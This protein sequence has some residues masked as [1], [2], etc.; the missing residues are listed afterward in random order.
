MQLP[1]KRPSSLG[2]FHEQVHVLPAIGWQLVDT[3]QEDPFQVEPI[4]QWL[5]IWRG[6]VLLDVQ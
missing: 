1:S 5:G 2:S 3:V 6:I 4:A